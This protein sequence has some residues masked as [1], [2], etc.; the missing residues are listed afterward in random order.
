MFRRALAVF[1]LS[2][3]LPVLAAAQDGQPDVYDQAQ[4]AGDEAGMH[5]DSGAH[6]DSPTAGQVFGNTE[7]VA[8]LLNFTLLIAILFFGLR[9]PL[10]TFLSNRKLALEEGLAEAQRMKQEAD[11]K[12]KEYASRLEKLD[13]EIDKLRAEMVK[14]GEAERDRIVQEAEAKAA[15]MRRDAD[16]LIEQQLK[17]L[18]E[19]LTREA[20]YA[21]V[22]TAEQVLRDKITAEDQQRLAQ[23]YLKRLA[24][25]A[26]RGRAAQQAATPTT[27]KAPQEEHA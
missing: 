4:E 26:P 5:E 21:A 19:D 15:R 11:A 7:F 6:G 27:P 14:A 17:Q 23:E 10:G 24:E 20:A 18:R 22:A 25:Y 16:F 3:A 2:F 13:H 1:A 12:Y 8:S 9:K